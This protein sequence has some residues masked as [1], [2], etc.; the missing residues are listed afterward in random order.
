VTR[1]DGAPDA[2]IFLCGDVMTGRGIDQILPH[3]GD[4]LLHEDYVRSALGYLE[5]AET[6][7]GAIPR[8]VGFDYIWGDAL[9][10]LAR[11]RP[12]ARIVNLETAV[13]ARGRPEPKGVN[14][15]MSPAD[16][17]LPPPALAAA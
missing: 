10:E 6:A 14:Y 8:P 1:S 9:D 2:T 5:L 4:P 17:A 16:L 11:R 3:P 13:T 7:S 12:A 15:R